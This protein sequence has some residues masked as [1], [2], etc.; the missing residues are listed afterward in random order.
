MKLRRLQI[1]NFRGITKLD[2]SLKDTT[3]LIGE[4]NTGKTAVLEALR[5]ALRD[6]RSRR[7]CVASPM[8]HL[9]ARSVSLKIP[10]MAFRS[11]RA[12]IV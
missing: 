12:P 9:V 7:C 5:F 4:N 6:V 1:E 10:F 3:V 11:E 2:M 8:T